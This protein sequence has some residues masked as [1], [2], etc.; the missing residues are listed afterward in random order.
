MS[1]VGEAKEEVNMR[2]GSI[3]LDTTDRSVRISTK[4]LSVLIGLLWMNKL[5]LAL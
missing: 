3:I 1:A 4:S 5:G 2:R